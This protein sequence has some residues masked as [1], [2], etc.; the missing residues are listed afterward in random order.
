MITDSDDY[1]S[2]DGIELS[3][4]DSHLTGT[5]SEADEEGEIIKSA[6]KERLEIPKETFA[7]RILRRKRSVPR[8]I[9]IPHL[10]QK[11]SRGKASK[12][13]GS[14]YFDEDEYLDSIEV[15]Q[16]F[17]KNVV[18][19]QKY[20]VFTFL[21]LTLYDQFKYFYNLYFLGTALT[22]FFPILKVGYL[23]TYVVPLAF[24]LALSIGKEGYD[25]IKRML[26]DKV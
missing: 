5:E 2:A 1:V 7:D 4:L 26:Q 24:V 20:N 23:F 8:I 15:K 17:P 21:P 25:D 9:S 19:N 22:Q 18:R 6:E 11:K 3:Q 13:E 10:Q 16:R 12:K 14:A